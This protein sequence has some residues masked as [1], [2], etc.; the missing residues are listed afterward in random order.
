MA[1]EVV[2]FETVG[3]T[4]AAPP[5]H[6]VQEREKISQLKEELEQKDE[7]I[8]KVNNKVLILERNYMLCT[9]WPIK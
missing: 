1:A 5:A 6:V 8:K 2:T 3:L 9:I 7:L 4:G